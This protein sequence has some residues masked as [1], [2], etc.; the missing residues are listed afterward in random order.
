M[1][2]QVPLAAILEKL[3]TD[4]DEN[5]HLYAFTLKREAAYARHYPLSTVAADDTVAELLASCRPDVTNFTEA[6]FPVQ[7]EV[8]SR[9][10]GGTV[11]EDHV[12]MSW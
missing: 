7:S 10:N 8:Q 1:D 5:I 2:F 6:T 4:V 3:P 9:S 12:T 11:S